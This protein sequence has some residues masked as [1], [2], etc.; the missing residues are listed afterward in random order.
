MRVSG[1]T[2]AQ[3]GAVLALCAIALT[4]AGTADAAPAPRLAESSFEQLAQPLPLP[5]DEKAKAG[6]AVR[7]ATA[8]ARAHGKLLLIDLGGNW[9]LDCRILAGTLALPD[10]A[11]FIRAHFE[12]VTVDLGRFTKN[13]GLAARYGAGY[14]QAVPTVLIV[15]PGSGR[16]VNAGHVAALSD[17]RSLSP[18][19]LADWLAQWT[20]DDTSTPRPQ[21]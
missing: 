12:V 21:P 3:L 19:A 2:I 4:T 9:C 1:H 15:A 6:E 13:M 18:Q 16:L 17:A 20:G 11:P 8:R 14:P 5:Y 10:L 7:A